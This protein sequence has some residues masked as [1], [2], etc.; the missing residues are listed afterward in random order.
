MVQRL[1]H[2]IDVDKYLPAHQH[3][4]TGDRRV[5]LIG[6]KTLHVP[7]VDIIHAVEGLTRYAVNA[8]HIAC[9]A[10]STVGIQL[11]P[12]DYSHLRPLT[13]VKQVM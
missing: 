8:Q 7:F 12:S 4:I 1:I 13:V 10:Y 6:M 3:K 9:V 2:T 11:F 5:V